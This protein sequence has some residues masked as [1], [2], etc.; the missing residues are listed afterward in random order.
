MLAW[1]PCVLLPPLFLNANSSLA[2]SGRP[3]RKSLVARNICIARNTSSARK[4]APKDDSY[5]KE[6]KRENNG[7]KMKKRNKTKKWLPSALFSL[8]VFSWWPLKTSC[9]SPYA[10]MYLRHRL[11]ILLQEFQNQKK[12]PFFSSLPYPQRVL[13]SE[14]DDDAFCATHGKPGQ[15]HHGLNFLGGRSCPVPTP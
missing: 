5:Q 9:Q 13:V 10:E 11:L 3:T 14:R 8:A 7:G 6:K 15:P 4:T 1:P 12:S 2:Q